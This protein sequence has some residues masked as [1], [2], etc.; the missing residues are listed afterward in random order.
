MAELPD[1][2]SVEMELLR[3]LAGF[4]EPKSA[5]DAYRSLGNKFSLPRA[6]RG[7]RMPNQGEP[8]WPNRV[9]TAMNNLVKHGYT[10]RVVRDKWIATKAGRDRVTFIDSIKINI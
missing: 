3:Y 9:R 8:H 1:T 10:E 2:H 4:I 7:Q 6:I 5:S